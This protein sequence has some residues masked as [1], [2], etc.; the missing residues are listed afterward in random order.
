MIDVNKMCYKCLRMLGDEEDMFA[1]KIVDKNGVE[2]VFMGHQACVQE[3]A[4]TLQQLY[5]GKN[6]E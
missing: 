2:K 4:E 1:F 6:D 5:G 3:I